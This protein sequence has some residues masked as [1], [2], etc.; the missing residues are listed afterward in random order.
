MFFGILPCVKRKSDCGADR[1][2]G[3][4]RV[5]SVESSIHPRVFGADLDLP[6]MRGCN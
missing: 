1:I 6:R 5:V 3:P 2:F 4:P